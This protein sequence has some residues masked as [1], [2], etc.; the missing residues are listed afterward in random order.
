MRY[1]C[2]ICL[3]DIKK[4]IKYSHVKS[5]S[6][7]DFEKSKHLILSLKNVELKDV[8]EILYLYM[9][10]HSKKFDQYLLKGQ[11]KLV[12]TNSQ[13]C[14]YLLTDMIKNT[15]KISWSIYLGEAI[16]S[17]KEEGYHF[18]HVAE[19][20]KITSAHKQI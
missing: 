10:D 7:K 8:D 3:R 4:K 5:R 11:F 15:T 9:K 1:Y 14:K 19:M 2:D 17:L 20:D 6:H 13:D 16:D 12:F 18:N